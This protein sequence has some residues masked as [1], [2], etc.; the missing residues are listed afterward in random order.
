MK[1]NVSMFGDEKQQ[2][3]DQELFK[4]KDFAIQT[5]TLW[6]RFCSVRRVQLNQVRST[7]FGYLTELKWQSAG[8]SIPALVKQLRPYALLNIIKT[9]M[10]IFAVFTIEIEPEGKEAEEQKAYWASI[11]EK[12]KEDIQNGSIPKSIESVP[13]TIEQDPTNKPI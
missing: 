8:E 9:L 4:A 10:D 5:I 11:T 7:G 1:V 12:T 6:M 3:T 2:V 13:L